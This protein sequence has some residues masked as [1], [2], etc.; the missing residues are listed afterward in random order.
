MV[1]PQ[2]AV[3]DDEDT[4]ESWG[5]ACI[6]VPCLDVN[7]GSIISKQFLSQAVNISTLNPWTW[8]RRYA[9]HVLEAINADSRYERYY[10]DPTLSQ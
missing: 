2:T 7:E 3:S 8:E 4:T 1:A 5:D 10:S 9:Q 6:F